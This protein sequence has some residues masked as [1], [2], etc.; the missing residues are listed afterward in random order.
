MAPAASQPVVSGRV[1]VTAPF[2][3]GSKSGCWGGHRRGVM[4]G[5]LR[6][7][8]GSL[9]VVAGLQVSGFGM[10]RRLVDKGCVG[11]VVPVSAGWLV[12]F[13]LVEQDESGVNP[14]Y[15]SGTRANNP[16]CTVS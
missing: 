1:T 11:Y 16:Y 3:R 13:Y 15:P 5:G 8:A 4:S 2:P 7:R 9:Y 6:R 12:V 14:P 10:S